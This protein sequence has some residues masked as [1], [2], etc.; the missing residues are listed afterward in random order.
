MKNII[1]ETFHI[2]FYNSKPATLE[3]VDCQF[4]KYIPNGEITMVQ[5]PETT[6]F[7]KVVHSIDPFVN[8]LRDHPKVVILQLRKPSRLKVI[9]WL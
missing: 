7:D 3:A 2:A 1:A 4:P 6:Q 8:F 5:I 9:F